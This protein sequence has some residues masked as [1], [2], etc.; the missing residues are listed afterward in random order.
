LKVEIKKI[1]PDFMDERGYIHNAFRGEEARQVTVLYTKK[2]AVRGNHY[3]T[4]RDPSNN[5]EKFLLIQGRMK[6]YAKDLK[7][8]EEMEE[9]IDDM[10]EIRIWPFVFHRFEALKDSVMIE[11]RER[12]Y[13]RNDPDTISP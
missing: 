2:G 6:F 5:P 9:I 8:G 10:T 12:E 1:K 13:D 7:S 3:H 11:Y 4:G